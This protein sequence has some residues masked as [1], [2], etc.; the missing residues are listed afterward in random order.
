MVR[1]VSG[2][3]AMQRGW[4]DHDMFAGDEYS[5]RDAWAWLIANAA[6]K[7]ITARIKGETVQLHRGELCFAQRFMAEKWGWSKSR[8]DRF[9]AQLRAEGMIE[10]RTK[11]GATAGQHA[12]QGQSI[13]TVC[14]YDRFQATRDD[15]RGNAQTENGATAGQQRGK[16]EEG[17]KGTI[18]PEEEVGGG[19]P[20]SYAFFGQTIRLTPQH[21]ER[22]RRSFHTI[23]DLEAELTVLDG[24]WQDQSADRRKKW[25]HPTMGMLNRK[26][27]E[28]LALRRDYDRSRITV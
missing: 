24:W 11:N 6:W 8:V 25:F 21:L 2:Y 4:H 13:I 3:V 9:I 15:C 26:H 14:N 16:E 17:N 22:W 28:N 18:E 12:G 7:P 10:T 23:G 5:R 27:Q 20:P 1:A 19:K